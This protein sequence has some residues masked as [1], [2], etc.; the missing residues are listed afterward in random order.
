MIIISL[1]SLQARP[2]KKEQWPLKDGLSTCSQESTSCSVP[3]L[4]GL[5]SPYWTTFCFPM[6]TRQPK[7]LSTSTGSFAG[8]EDY[9]S[10]HEIFKNKGKN[11]QVY[12]TG[13]GW[14]P[15]WLLD[16]VASGTQLCIGLAGHK[17]HSCLTEITGW[18]NWLTMPGTPFWVLPN[19]QVNS[20][21]TIEI[22][23]IQTWQSLHNSLFM[24]LPRLSLKMA[25][26]FVNC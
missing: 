7:N 21:G 12:P 3:T 17:G 14:T 24:G 23:E 25:G 2:H 8:K 16:T 20:T 4:S 10:I 6:T 18:P 9:Y 1:I 26:F 15:Q 19:T 11:L 13:M 22:H 5:P